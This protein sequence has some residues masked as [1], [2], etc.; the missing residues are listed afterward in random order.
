M[1]VK[2]RLYHYP[3]L[4]GMVVFILFVLSYVIATNLDYNGVV[5]DCWLCLFAVANP[6]AGIFQKKWA[7]YT[8]QSIVTIIFITIAMYIFTHYVTNNSTP[9]YHAAHLFVIVCLTA[10]YFMLMALSYLFRSIIL[11]LMNE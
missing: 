9:Q 6:I 4:Q 3:H 1:T 2:Q 11:G 8:L 10:F 7:R 5:S